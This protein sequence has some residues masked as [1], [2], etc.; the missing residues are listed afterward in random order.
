MFSV[1][2]QCRGPFATRYLQEGPGPL[3]GV[4]FFSPKFPAYPISSALAR[5][6][7]ACFIPYL[8]VLLGTYSFPAHLLAPLG[9][10]VYHSSILV[11]S[12]GYF[13]PATVSVNISLFSVLFISAVG[14]FKIGF[15]SFPIINFS[16]GRTGWLMS[17][18]LLFLFLKSIFLLG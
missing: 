18:W 15:V 8:S 13:V 1:V 14:N 6:L 10:S 16:L 11:W 9:G 17:N 5:H 12:V 3:H 4:A 7:L 2:S